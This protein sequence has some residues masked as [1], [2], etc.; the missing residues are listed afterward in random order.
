MQALTQI[1]EGFEAKIPHVHT[2]YDI[3]TGKI[4]IV[5]FKHK[6][7]LWW[8][9]KSFNQNLNL[10]EA[11]SMIDNYASK[12]NIKKILWSKNDI[13]F[14]MIDIQT[15]KNIY[16]RE[17]RGLKIVLSNAVEKVGRKEKERKAEILRKFH[18]DQVTLVHLT[19]R[20]VSTEI[21]KK[22]YWKGISRDVS[23]FLKSCTECGEQ[24]KY[25][26]DTNAK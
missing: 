16:E 2:S 17:K 7:K 23:M 18:V 12:F 21:M 1:Y 6:K 13:I 24:Q 3:E 5:V 9:S 4:T 20:K 22:Y 14:N 19:P 15:F 10:H 11:F 25:Q 26:T 8:I